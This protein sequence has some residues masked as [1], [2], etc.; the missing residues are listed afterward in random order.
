MFW[1]IY[2]FSALYLSHLIASLVKQNYINIFILV[3]VLCLTPSHTDVTKEAYAPS[4]FNFLYSILFEQNFSTVPI[5]PL[6]LSISATLIVLLFVSLA[7][8]IFFQ[9]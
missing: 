7:K 2:L 3:L 1:V 5:R 9:R 8:K 4:I 6:V